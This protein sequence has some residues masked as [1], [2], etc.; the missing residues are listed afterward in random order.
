VHKA[1]QLADRVL[2]MRRG[3]VELSGQAAEL[4][5]DPDAFRAAYFSDSLN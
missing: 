1:L 3:R 5:Q 2:V 4:R